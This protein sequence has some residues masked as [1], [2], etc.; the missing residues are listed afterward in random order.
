MVSKVSPTL[1]EHNAIRVTCRHIGNFHGPEEEYI[2][3]LYQGNML[4]DNK[5]HKG[6]HFD[7]KDLSY[8]TAYSVKVG[9]MLMIV[10]VYSSKFFRDEQI[11]S[12]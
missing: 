12:F 10:S 11:F 9:M 7:F 5:T 6:C 2:A 8:S 4:K 3:E 1:S